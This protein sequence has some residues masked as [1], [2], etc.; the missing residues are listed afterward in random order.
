MFTKGEISGVIIR[1]LKKF[2]DSRGWLVEV[3]RQDELEQE[4]HPVMGYVSMT[5]AG[6]ARGPHEHVEQADIFAFLG[7]STFEV[8]LWDNRE[9]SPTY[10]RH[11]VVT[12]GESEPK[13]IVIPPGV[14]H[15]YRNIGD[16]LGMVVNAPN[17]LYAGTGKK[18][19]VDEIRHEED[20]NTIF[21]LD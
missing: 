16:R 15:A 19:K 13:M 17:R 8:F 14:V 5:E 1:D 6:V 7:P 3:F 2:V 10:R 21:R 20:P 9:S 4:F 18:E 12:A 11:H